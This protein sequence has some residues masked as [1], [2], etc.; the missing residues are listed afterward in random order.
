[1][2]DVAAFD[3]YDFPP[4]P[5]KL[6]D[7]CKA[8]HKTKARITKFNLEEDCVS[9]QTELDQRK[10]YLEG[11]QKENEFLAPTFR[12]EECLNMLKG[13]DYELITSEGVPVCIGSGLCGEILLAKHRSTNELVAI[14]IYNKF[15]PKLTSML[16]EAAIQSRASTVLDGEVKVPKFVGFF[17]LKEASWHATKMAKYLFVTQ[18][19]GVIRNLPHAMTLLEAG[20][21]P[22][23]FT[24]QEW[25]RICQMLITAAD[26]MQNHDIYH[27]DIKLA[28]IVLQLD[29]DIVTPFLIDFGLALNSCGV[30]QRKTVYLPRPRKEMPQHS[31]PELYKSN[32]PLP[33]SDIYSIARLI[34]KIG[35]F[36]RCEQL[37]KE[38]KEYRKKKPKHRP[39][40][41][42]LSNVVKKCFDTME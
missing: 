4:I 1:M 28:N 14:K 37:M 6:A 42:Y 5:T 26:K 29:G 7:H 36:I 9:D 32:K 24:Q 39:G 8:P 22:N 25:P 30:S 15:V 38:M 20:H 11:R 12:Q 19:C 10:T 16:K 23:F 35:K 2:A 40:H 41:I 31:P 21:I 34:E 3:N 18:F 17:C 27:L 33:T 13:N